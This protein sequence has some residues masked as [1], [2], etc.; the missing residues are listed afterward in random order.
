MAAK[1]FQIPSTYDGLQTLED[2]DPSIPFDDLLVNYLFIYWIGG[3]VCIIYLINFD[4]LQITNV[5]STSPKGSE[6]DSFL[7]KSESLHSPSQDLDT[8]KLAAQTIILHLLTQ[9]GHFPM[10]NGSSKCG[11]LVSENDD[12]PGLNSE[13]DELSTYIFSLPNVQVI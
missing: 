7:P 5:S 6:K 11:S 13:L 12:L 8:V 10:S 9:L 4:I 3:V 2:F 1:G